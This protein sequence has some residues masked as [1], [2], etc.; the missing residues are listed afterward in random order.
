M[1]VTLVEPTGCQMLLGLTHDSSAD[2]LPLPDQPHVPSFV[3]IEDWLG[4]INIK[5]LPSCFEQ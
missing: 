4:I 2:Y 3:V 1:L 5:T